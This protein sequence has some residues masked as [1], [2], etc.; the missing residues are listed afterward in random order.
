[1]SR[2]CRLLAISELHSDYQHKGK[3]CE[4]RLG[5]L[6]PAEELGSPQGWAHGGVVQGEG[7]DYDLNDGDDAGVK[8]GALSGEK[9]VK[10][11]KTRQPDHPGTEQPLSEYFVQHVDPLPHHRVQYI[12]RLRRALLWLLGLQ[13]WYSLLQ[14]LERPIEAILTRQKSSQMFT[15]TLWVCEPTCF[16]CAS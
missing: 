2:L 7:D 12:V 6:C 8:A 14:C 5:K 1:M 10:K 13:P 15:A 4:F 11:D 16:D 9:G 3:D